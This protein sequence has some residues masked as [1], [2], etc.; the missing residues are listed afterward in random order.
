MLQ[1]APALPG[2]HISQ[3]IYEST[4]SLIYRATR[5]HDVLP[6]VLKVLKPDYPDPEELTR[7]NQEYE[8][9]RQLNGAGAVKVWSRTLS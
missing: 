4:N 3:Q 1:P 5:E 8:I 2:Y 7:Y 6:V 9:I